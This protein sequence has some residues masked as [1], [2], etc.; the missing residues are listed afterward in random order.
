MTSRLRTIVFP[1][2]G[3]GTR[4]LPGTKVI[5]KEMLPVM[6][7]P[8]IQ[9]AA[10]EA[11][12]A[13]ADTLVFV[14]NRNNRAIND[15]F[16][17]AFEPEQRLE[18]GNKHELLQIVRDVLPSHVRPV[19]VLQSDARGLG[20]AVLCARPAVA[21]GVFGV[22]LPDDLIINRDGPGALQQMAEVQRREGGSVIA[23]EPV[24]PRETG[25]YGIVCGTSTNPRLMR[26]E[27]IVEKP[28]PDV[29]PSN[30][31]VVG[32]YV[33]DTRIFELLERTRPGAGGEIQLTDAIAVLL[34]EQ[35]VH[36]Y[37]FDGVRYD[38]E[39]KLGYVHATLRLALDG[40]EIG[41][42]VRRL[43]SGMV[44][45]SASQLS[46]PLACVDAS[47]GTSAAAGEH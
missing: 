19:F 39:T 1:V 34:Q 6:D 20:H 29:A 21:P 26:V 46:A 38:C 47:H 40:D 24:N 5:P 30:L 3:L 23:V 32:R 31:A 28:R 45:G 17:T 44:Q 37:R 25:K 33:L 13:G 42:D 43:M 10:D 2:A 9:W 22:I 16:D 18:R 7:Q 8:M 14:V 27:G 4:F 15:H 36:A 41:A 35:P 11:V 12:E